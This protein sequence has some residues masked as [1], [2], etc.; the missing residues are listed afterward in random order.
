MKKESANDFHCEGYKKW[1]PNESS[2]VPTNFNIQSPP[3]IQQPLIA[4]LAFYVRGSVSANE[5]LENSSKEIIK[6]ISSYIEEF[7]Q[8]DIFEPKYKQL[9]FVV[10]NS[11]TGKSTLISYLAGDDLV[12]KTINGKL[13]IDNNT[14]SDIEIGHGLESKTFF[15]QFKDI[16]GT[17][18]CDMPG[19]GDTRGIVEEI[20]KAIFMKKVSDYI[21]NVKIL[22]TIAYSDIDARAE[23][24]RSLIKNLSSFIRNINDFDNGIN[25]IVTKVDNGVKIDNN[26]YVSKTDD[27][28]TAEIL[29]TLNSFINENPN[30]PSFLKSII[31]HKHIKI[32]RKPSGEGTL[33]YLT[34]PGLGK[35]FENEQKSIQEA[36]TNTL[37]LSKNNIDFGYSITSNAQLDSVGIAKELRTKMAFDMGAIFEQIEKHYSSKVNSSADIYQLKEIL[38]NRNWNKDQ[39]NFSDPILFL[40]GVRQ[41]VNKFRIGITQAKFKGFL[42][43]N[44]FLNFLGHLSEQIDK[45]TYYQA[46]DSLL[47]FLVR[48][49]EFNQILINLVNIQLNDEN[50]I[51]SL[52]QLK[53]NRNNEDLISTIVRDFGNFTEAQKSQINKLLDYLLKSPESKDIGDRRIIVGRIVKLSEV[54]DFIKGK[55]TESLCIYSSKAL[56]LD[57]KSLD[58]PGKNVSIIAPEWYMFGS[59][60]ITLDGLDGQ[61]HDLPK[62]TDGATDGQKGADGLPGKPGHSAGNF[63]GVGNT[64]YNSSALTISAIGG[65]GGLGQNGGNGHDGRSETDADAYK[66]SIHTL[67]YESPDKYKPIVGHPYGV[68]RKKTTSGWG[69]ITDYEYQDYKNEGL[70]GQVGGNG[71]AGGLGGLGGKR[72][73]F[74]IFNTKNQ[75]I[76]AVSEDGENGQDGNPGNGGIGGKHGQDAYTTFYVST[77]NRSRGSSTCGLE[78]SRMSGDKGRANNGISLLSPGS[79]EP[80]QEQKIEMIWYKPFIEYRKFMAENIGNKFLKH[81]TEELLKALSEIQ[82]RLD[83]H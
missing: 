37:Y 47:N 76:S 40:E 58:L 14:T 44:E 30:E 20:A 35:I 15:P 83:T 52:D 32:F 81:N 34:I 36:I 28:I 8:K 45:Y 79:K 22:V 49:E 11:G 53:N 12:A 64:F 82:G 48:E 16:L 1:L 68:P 39:F 67:S 61:A 2:I 42:A 10:G 7:N 51:K 77:N 65:K 60:T 9:V 57:D 5:V 33:K 72:G 80:D 18:Y 50:V 73:I 29:G 25:I 13:I 24:L 70:N 59:N 26:A 69:S 19:F 75:G 21:N 41:K 46:L 66:N 43:N 78:D 3:S 74:E 71:G 62:A 31:S 17:I 54:L 56:I 63:L 27:E 6:K 38:D 23:G 4:P 55:N